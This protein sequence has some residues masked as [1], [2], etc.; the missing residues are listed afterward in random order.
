MQSQSTTT[1]IEIQVHAENSGALRSYIER[2][3]R[4][5][6][7]RYVDRLG[8]VKVRIS[9]VT[10][11]HGLAEKSC[12]IRV[13]LLRSGVLLLQEARDA[14]VY[15]AIDSAAERIDRSFGRHFERNMLKPRRVVTAA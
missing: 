4:V 2:R 14:N 15:A 3:L 7:S 8:T 11:Q 6:L 9:E 10:G 12:E 13:Q 5:A 1:Q